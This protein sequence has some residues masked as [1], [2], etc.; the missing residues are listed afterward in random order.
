MMEKKATPPN[1]QTTA[2]IAA[3]TLL[4]GSSAAGT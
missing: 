4:D 3:K 2:K 1:R